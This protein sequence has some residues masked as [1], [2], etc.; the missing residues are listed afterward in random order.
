MGSAGEDPRGNVLLRW[1]I[2]SYSSSSMAFAN[3]IT[4]RQQTLVA[5]GPSAEEY[6]HGGGFQGHGGPT[7][8]TRVPT[9]DL[10]LFSSSCR[11]DR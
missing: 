5:V 11:G 9:S 1:G 10:V 2:T 3:T 4:S 6:K 8:A 7:I